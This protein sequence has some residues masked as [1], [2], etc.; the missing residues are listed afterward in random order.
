MGFEVERQKNGT[1]DINLQHRWYDGK[2]MQNQ[3]SYRRIW[4]STETGDDRQ[5][6]LEYG[7]CR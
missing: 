4:V 2:M 6:Q 1:R 7:R 3:S 5:L